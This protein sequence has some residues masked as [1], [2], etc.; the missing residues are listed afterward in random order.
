MSDHAN[1]QQQCDWLRMYRRLKRIL[2]VFGPDDWDLGRYWVFDENWGSN[3]HVVTI[4]DLALLS[5]EV[6]TSLR[7]T[8]TDFD[9]WEVVITLD[10]LGGESWPKMGL[11]LRQHEIIDGLHRSYFPEIFVIYIMRMHG[12]APL[13][14]RLRR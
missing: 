3:Q 14:T 12:L 13:T 9:N 10:A 5:P 11:Y 6:I 7:R 2:R 8:L 1:L 4:M